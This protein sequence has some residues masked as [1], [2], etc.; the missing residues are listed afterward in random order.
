M[1]SGTGKIEGNNEVIRPSVTKAPEVA[2]EAPISLGGAH[3]PY[4]TLE[5]IIDT[6]DKGARYIKVQRIGKG[7]FG[8]AY[9]VKPNP[10][11]LPAKHMQNESQYKANRLASK[12]LPN[13]HYVA[14]V[15]DLRMM[16]PQDRQYATTEII[17]LAHTHHFSTIR[18][19]EHFL[20]DSDDE[21]IVIITE[22]ANHGD[23]YH[24]LNRLS[25]E[26]KKLLQLTEREACVYF[27]QALLALHHI[28]SRRMIH[29]DVK[30]ANLFLTSSGFMK[31]GDF[32]FS[33]KYESTVS[34]ETIAGTFLG[35][36]YYLSPEMWR[37]QRY[38]KK[39]D[40]W[41]IG[42]VL[43]EMLMDGARPFDAGN[44]P[45]LKEMVVNKEVELPEVP[46]DDA[47]GRRGK[48]SNEVRELV[49]SIFR[50]D[51]SKRPSTGE[52]LH[53]PLMQHYLYLFEKH[54]ESLIRQDEEA[55]AANPN[56]DI[57]TLHF[58]CP[59]DKQLV[60]D[61]LLEAKAAVTQEIQK[62]MNES[63]VPFYQGVIYK[64]SR[65]GV[66][67]ERFLTLSDNTLTISLGR[68]REAAGGERSKAVSLQDIKS[69]SPCSAE[70]GHVRATLQ[71]QNQLT[72][73]RFVPPYAFAVS[74]NSTNSIVFGVESE[75][76][77]D[78]W[79]NVLMRALK[80]A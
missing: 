72:A 78:R 73:N 3:S 53:T 11:Y 38:G 60:L 16:H 31:L 42:V 2:T 28:H 12:T 15:M 43:Y 56:V 75:Q 74:M 34:S 58:K 51:P 66:W 4:T 10:N 55:R 23:L 62:E 52:L 37:G 46:P 68:G 5:D 7:A 48:F 80:M 64:D 35:T 47:G 76:E 41:A 67:K 14:K 69:V 54:V 22:F 77:L 21:T 26:G 9:I 57:A 59:E 63:A 70:D 24:N 49:K 13:V 36:P 50:K 61:G 79:M 25:P 40:V 71:A 32:G 33:Q 39:A 6:A 20:L 45:D 44:L 1:G 18:Y 8:D 19:Y 30:S 65:N 29:R 17:C 27:V